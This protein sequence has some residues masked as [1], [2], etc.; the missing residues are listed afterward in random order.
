[1]EHDYRWA[2]LWLNDRSLTKS[3][4]LCKEWNLHK[5]GLEK[6]PERPPKDQEQGPDG[7]PGDA[8]GSDANERHDFLGQLWDRS[9]IP[10]DPVLT[11]T[12]INVGIARYCPARINQIIIREGWK[13]VKYMGRSVPGR[14]GRAPIRAKNCI[15]QFR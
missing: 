1:M 5:K 9:I 11:A 3:A 15:I 7:G 10:P 8:H 12:Y 2:N 4:G 6:C 14:T 13:L